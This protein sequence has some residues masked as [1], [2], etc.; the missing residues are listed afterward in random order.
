MS[1]SRDR[2]KAVKKLRTFLFSQKIDVRDYRDR[3]DE[4]FSAVFLPNYVDCQE[5]DYGD[6]A[7]DVITPEMYS[8][9]RILLYIHGGSFV[10]GSKKAYRSFVSS[11]AT[12]VS[13]KAVVPEF[14]LAPAHPYP[15]AVE[16]VQKVFKA[17]FTEFH[18]QNILSTKTDSKPK[19]PEIIIAADSSGASIAM[20]LVLSLNE[21]FRATLRSLIFFSPWLDISEENEKLKMRKCS[22]D[23]FTAESVRFA[24]E[25]YVPTAENRKNPLVSP[26]YATKEMLA[27]FPPVYIQYG[28]KDM[29][30]EDY[31]RFQELL[32]SAGVKCDLDMW[33]GMMP[34]FEFADEYLSESHLAVE[35]IGKMIT[36]RSYE[37]ESELEIGLE[38]ERVQTRTM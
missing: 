5:K 4:V 9:D 7:C 20:A 26:L 35:K 15:F 19:V 25:N 32:F 29:F 3:I 14:D 28:S 13:A 8:F 11:L 10:G 34:L 31:E 24:A 6:V 17:V 37:N 22:D 12:A 23:V 27:K 36:A 30:V 1:S 16:S 21:R 2:Q 18:V 38:L 33:D